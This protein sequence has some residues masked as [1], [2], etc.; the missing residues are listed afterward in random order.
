MAYQS[1]DKVFKKIIRKYPQEFLIY[2]GL[3]YEFIKMMDTTVFG[4]SGEESRLDILMHV[5]KKGNIKNSYLNNEVHDK[6]E[7]LELEEDL[8]ILLDIELQSTIVREY[9]INRTHTYCSKAHSE[10]N[11]PVKPLIL[12]TVEPKSR[13]INS[14]V[15]KGEKFTIN[16]ISLTEKD[17]DKCLN[18]ITKKVENNEEL[19]PYDV[20]DL[21]FLQFMT[22][23]TYSKS[24]LYGLSLRLIKEANMDMEDRQEIIDL[25]YLYLDDTVKIE[26]YEKVRGDLMTGIRSRY[27]QDE[28]NQSKEEGIKIGEEKVMNKIVVNLLKESNDINYIQRIT[29][30]PLSKIEN[31]ARMAS[32]NIKV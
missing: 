9:L 1:K 28:K 21:I 19:N 7:Q 25:L 27:I 17:A 15:L 22:S 32:I 6:K 31:I 23:R 26:D 30:M 10:Y 16:I 4:S 3:E 14:E 11:L 13:I 24:E 2:L 18:K 5:R 12:S 20:F 29:D 8:D